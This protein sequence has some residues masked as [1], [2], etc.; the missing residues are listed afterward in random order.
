M[1]TSPPQSA[2]QPRHVDDPSSESSSTTDY[3]ALREQISTHHPDPDPQLGRA[4]R[5]IRPPACGTSGCL[6]PRPQERYT[7]NKADANFGKTS[8]QRALLVE[9][10]RQEVL[11]L[12][13]EIAF[14]ETIVEEREQGIQEI[15]QQIGEVNEIFKDLAVRVHKQGA[16]IDDIGSN[17]E[18][19]HAET[20]QAR[21]NLLKLQRLKDQI[22]LWAIMSVITYNGQFKEYNLSVDAHN[23]L[24]WS[25]G[26]EFNLLTMTLDK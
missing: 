17:I 8:E 18:H 15:Q 4:Q 12:D 13:N 11:F 16:M 21:S 1:H 14:N 6:D 23:D 25:L 5:D 9:S 20:A 22:L 19:S 26:R 24:T 3:A 2:Y 10:R 7:P